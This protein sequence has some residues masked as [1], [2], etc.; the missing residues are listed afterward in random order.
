[1]GAVRDLCKELG[2]DVT[3]AWSNGGRSFEKYILALDE[4]RMGQDRD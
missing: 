3:S 2:I 4:V 1:M